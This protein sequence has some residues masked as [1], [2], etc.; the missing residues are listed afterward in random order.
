MRLVRDADSDA[1]DADLSLKTVACLNHGTAGARQDASRGRGPI[2]TPPCEP[3][4]T[5]MDPAMS[6]S[7]HGSL[8]I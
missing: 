1:V 5:K 6:F 4:P 8:E 2:W 3:G 7:L